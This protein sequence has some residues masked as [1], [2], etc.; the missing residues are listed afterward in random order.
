M[1]HE[2]L[3]FIHEMSVEGGNVA[4]PTSSRAAS[5]SES[6]SAQLSR[7]D[8]QI[9]HEKRVPPKTTQNGN[10]QTPM[11]KLSLFDATISFVVD[12]E[13][14]CEERKDLLSSCVCGRRKVGKWFPVRG[15]F[16]TGAS[17]DFVSDS[18]IERAGLK[19]A[20]RDALEPVE[21]TMFGIT[22]TFDKCIS[23]SWQLKDRERSWTQ[24]FWVAPDTKEFDLV[25]GEP[26]MLVNGYAMMEE[27]KIRRRRGPGQFFGM[28]N[29]RLG[30][31]SKGKSILRMN[32]PVGTDLT[33]Y[34]AESSGKGSRNTGEEQ[35]ITGTQ[36]AASFA[37]EYCHTAP[38]SCSQQHQC[39]QHWRRQFA[40]SDTEG[41]KSIDDHGIHCNSLIHGD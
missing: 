26:W 11:E 37:I 33:S 30:R 6:V 25:I 32:R 40:Y 1:T 10:A 15:K 36:T 38:V 8:L 16:D 34:S 19:S 7:Y 21:V 39:R 23:L 9:P 27:G 24:N 41:N 5:I 17:A 3:R 13:I 4:T 18:I 20:V 35:G 29:L 12:E 31:K 22:F 28:L 14:D 2:L